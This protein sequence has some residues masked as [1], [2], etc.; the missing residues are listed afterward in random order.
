[1]H[2][3]IHV[4]IYIHTQTCVHLHMIIG[5]TALHYACLHGQAAAVKALLKSGAH[6]S[7]ENSLGV[8]PKDMLNLYEISRPKVNCVWVKGVCVPRSVYIHVHINIH[9][10]I[11]IQIYICMYTC[12]YIHISIYM[13]ICKYMYIYICVC[14]HI[15][16]YMCIYIYICIYI[17]I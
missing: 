6:P 15:P 2:T 3:Y 1:M 17:H 11:S 10:C 12:R 13:Y 4:H 5:W 7:P 16:I 8:T 14:I 9:L